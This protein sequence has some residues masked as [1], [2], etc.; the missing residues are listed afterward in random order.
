MIWCR[1]LLLRALMLALLLFVVGES[2]SYW[3]PE[4]KKLLA[5]RPNAVQIAPLR[6]Q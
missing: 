2:L 4:I 5:W 6:D 3:T 1:D